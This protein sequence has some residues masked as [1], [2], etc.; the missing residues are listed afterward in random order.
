MPSL[1]FTDTYV[2]YITTKETEVKFFAAL[3]DI[4]AHNMKVRASTRESEHPF[5][6]G[7]LGRYFK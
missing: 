2:N 7:R 3:K 5:G 6:A 4:S 1:S